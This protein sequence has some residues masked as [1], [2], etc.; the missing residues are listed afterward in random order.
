MIHGTC[1]HVGFL[2]TRLNSVIEF[3]M[4][5]IR[6]LEGNRKRVTYLMRFKN[7]ICV[8]CTLG[9]SFEVDGIIHFRD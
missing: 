9:E 1:I 2:K 5:V 6:L 3:K 7:E 4:I 8:Q